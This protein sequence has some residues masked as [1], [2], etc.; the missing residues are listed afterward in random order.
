MQETAEII[1]AEM[2]ATAP[3]LT[4]RVLRSD[5]GPFYTVVHEIEFE[6]RAARAAFWDNW[7]ATRSTP[8][9]WQKWNQCLVSDGFN[10]TW[11]VIE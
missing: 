11:F 5:V 10:E 2:E 9:F 4:S 1:K 6:D 7:I 3:E 8:E